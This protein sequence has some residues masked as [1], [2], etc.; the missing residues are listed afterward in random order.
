MYVTWEDIT[1]RRLLV[2]FMNDTCKL[3][4]A[5]QKL[6]LETSSESKKDVMIHD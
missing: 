1:K 3:L 6:E 5:Y 4:D 2:K